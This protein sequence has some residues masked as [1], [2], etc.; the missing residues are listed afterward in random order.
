MAAASAVDWRTAT[1]GDIGLLG[2]HLTSSQRQILGNNGP[3]LC[4]CW[5]RRELQPASQL[6][7]CTVPHKSTSSAAKQAHRAADQS[8]ALPGTAIIMTETATPARCLDL[9]NNPQASRPMRDSNS[10]AA[11]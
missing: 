10:P 2:R 1:F 6:D 7:Y 4:L 11:R 3:G 8:A 9:T 5:R